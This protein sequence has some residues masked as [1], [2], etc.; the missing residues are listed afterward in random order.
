METGGSQAGAKLE[1]R[2]NWA[3]AR[4][5]PRGNRPQAGTPNVPS[6]ILITILQAKLCQNIKSN[7]AHAK[8]PNRS[9]QKMLYLISRWRHCCSPCCYAP[10][11]QINLIYSC[12]SLREHKPTRIYSQSRFGLPN[13]RNQCVSLHTQPHKLRHTHRPSSSDKVVS[14]NIILSSTQRRYHA[15][16]YAQGFC[17]QKR[18]DLNTIISKVCERRSQ[19]WISIMICFTSIAIVTFA[20]CSPCRF[21]KAC[22]MLLAIAEN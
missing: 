5:Q 17:S 1:P 10:E 20:C 22:L 14:Q 6:T 16:V 15:R 21:R 11:R 19:L 12:V 3:G 7:R 8:L 4:R 13:D 2:G 18:C 9:L